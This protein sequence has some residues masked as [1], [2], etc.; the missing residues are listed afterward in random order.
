MIAPEKPD[1]RCFQSLR[2][3]RHPGGAGGGARLLCAS[4]ADARKRR[5]FDNSA[6][7][8]EYICERVEEIAAESISTKGSFAMSIGAS[9]FV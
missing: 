4:G 2:H 1:A 6:D 3:A 5:V 7:I 8:G 9:P